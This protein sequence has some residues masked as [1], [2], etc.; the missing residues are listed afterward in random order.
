MSTNNKTKTKTVSES[1]RQIQTKE[2][3]PVW[4]LQQCEQTANGATLYTL[5]RETKR[6][7][8]IS[9]ETFLPKENGERECDTQLEGS[10]RAYHLPF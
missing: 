6:R 7:I 8:L 1:D 2:L 3:H 5:L 4:E 9:T 10:T